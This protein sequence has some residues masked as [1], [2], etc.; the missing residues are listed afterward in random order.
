[1]KRIVNLLMV[2]LAVCAGNDVA[3]A[4]EMLIRYENP[5]PRMTYERVSQNGVELSYTHIDAPA[6]YKVPEE[7]KGFSNGFSDNSFTFD[8]PLTLNGKDAVTLQNVL[9]DHFAVTD[10][11]TGEVR[12][13]PASVEELVKER[14]HCRFSEEATPAW[15]PDSAQ[16]NCLKDVMDVGIYWITSRV[17]GFEFAVDQYY[18]G[19]TGASVMVG[20][21]Y[22]NYDIENQRELTADLC[23][24]PGLETVIAAELQCSPELWDFLW[25]EYK[26]EP[27]VPKNFKI[28]DDS[29]TFFFRGMKLL[30]VQP[31]SWM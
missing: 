22:L 19:G 15:L 27:F 1:M 14:T 29:I 16:D 18:G 11:E 17:I 25:D 24:L 31:E 13:R 12:Y 26:S 3:Q 10:F 28:D 21:Y 9:L 20:S 5:K 2:L 6:T 23:F 8:W 30:P 7:D 4:D